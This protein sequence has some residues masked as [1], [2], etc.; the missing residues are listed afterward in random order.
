MSD[1]LITWEGVELELEDR[2]LEEAT[3]CASRMR[4]VLEEFEGVQSL[5]RRRWID[6]A[7]GFRFVRTS[8]RPSPAARTSPPAR[9]A[10]Q[11]SPTTS[12]PPRPRRD[13]PARFS[14]EWWKARYARL[15]ADRTR[16][17]K[18]RAQ[19]NAWA[20]QKYRDDA[21]YRERRREEGARRA[22]AWYAQVKADPD[23]KRRLREAGR[24]R[25]NAWYARLKSDPDQR[26]RY[27]AL[28]RKAAQRSNASYRRRKKEWR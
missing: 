22:R 21:A 23:R 10:A 26:E 12:R 2:E 15:K 4:E 6:A 11:T 5:G 13:G 3:L 16:Y 9:R 27:E 17:E 24:R 28:K 14:P 18:E 20:R 7:E 25:A 1:R 8:T 19:K